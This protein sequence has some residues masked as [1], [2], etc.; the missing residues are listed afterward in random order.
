MTLDELAQPRVLPDLAGLGARTSLFGATMR[1]M[2]PAGPAGWLA[3]ISYS[4]AA[5][6]AA[7]RGRAATQLSCDLPD[8]RLLP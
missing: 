1:R 3:A 5:D 2:R 7:Y 4:V 8:R 6:L